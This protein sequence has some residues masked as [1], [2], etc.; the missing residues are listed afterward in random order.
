MFY[1][2]TLRRGLVMMGHPDAGIKN[3]KPNIIAGPRRMPIT[4]PNQMP[5]LLIKICDFTYVN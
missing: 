1:A 2:V 5:S 3:K 4:S